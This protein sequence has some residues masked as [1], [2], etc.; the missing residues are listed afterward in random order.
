ML[1]NQAYLNI[2]QVPKNKQIP[3]TVMTTLAYSPQQSFTFSLNLELPRLKAKKQENWLKGILNGDDRQIAEMYRK[4]MPLVIG[5]IRKNRGS[6][7]DAQD[8]F[9]DAIMIIHEK[10]RAGEIDQTTHFKAYFIQVCKYTWM[11]KLRRKH[12]QNISIDAEQFSPMVADTLSI[13]E[14]LYQQEMY[15]LYREKFQLLTAQQQQILKLCFAGKKLKEVAEIMGLA[16][17]G[18]AKK[19]K[20]MAKKRLVELIQADVRYQELVG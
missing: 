8:V 11:N 5:M 1:D 13:E 12:N 15:R 16:S 2:N 4:F 17:E 6:E 18:Y 20:F 14:D 19:K 9:Q 7:E 3:K 10:A